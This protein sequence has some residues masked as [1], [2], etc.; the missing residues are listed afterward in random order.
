MDKVAFVQNSHSY[1]VIKLTT[2]YAVG[3]NLPVNNSSTS[4][5]LVEFQQR[6]IRYSAGAVLCAL[7]NKRNK[8]H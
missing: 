1:I 2:G 5:T 8:D 3:L 6:H 7:N 4:V